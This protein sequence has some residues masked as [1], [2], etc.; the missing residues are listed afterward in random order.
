MQLGTENLMSAEPVMFQGAYQE[1][2]QMY[3]LAHLAGDSEE[4][5]ENN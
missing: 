3:D 4:M 5:L 2:Q 1:A